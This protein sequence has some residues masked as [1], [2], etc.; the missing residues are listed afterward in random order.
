MLVRRMPTGPSTKRG[1]YA[2]LPMHGLFAAVA[3]QI[4]MLAVA[5]LPGESRIVVGKVP[6]T[7]HMEQ[8]FYC[9]T[10]LVHQQSPRQSRT[11]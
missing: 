7:G 5:L 3:V 10:A 9:A 1:A 8:V 6:G 2:S 11:R 4:L